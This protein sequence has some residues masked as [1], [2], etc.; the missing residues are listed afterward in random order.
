MEPSVTISNKW[1]P[2]LCAKR[3]KNE[4][5]GGERFLEKKLAWLVNL[6]YT[7]AVCVNLNSRLQF[8]NAALTA[9]LRFWE[10]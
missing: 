9:A 1:S 3:G 6:A 7:I 5:L 10:E 2:Q 4:L 8:L